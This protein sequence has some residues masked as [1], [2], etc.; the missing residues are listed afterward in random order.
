MAKK[1][2]KTALAFQQLE[3]GLAEL[4]ESGDWQRY[5]KIQSQFYNYSFNNVLLIL[6]QFPGASRVAGYQRWQELG[7]Q[8]KKGSKSIKI[9]APLKRKVEKENDNGELETKTGIFGFRTVNVFDISQTE[10]EDLPEIAS[11]LT[12]DDQ[13]L[14][15][16]LTAFSHNNQVPVFFKGLLGRANGC[17]RYDA[18]SG[19]P[20]EI[21]VDPLLPKQH[22]A[23]TLSHE[24]AHSIL[25]SR[26]QY[27][28]HIPR[29]QAELEAESVAFIVLHHFGIDSSDYSFP[30]VAGWQ[31]GEDALENLRQSGML[32]QK[33]AN[34]IIDWIETN[35]PTQL[36]A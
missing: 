28:D 34:Q 14:I 18:I 8:V 20:I 25:H 17:C 3:V 21:V 7:R 27:N 22:Q 2:N 35:F 11:P 5:L 23:K 6:S 32:I 36:A 4:L 16:R 30:Y 31:Q 29:S 12:G 33:A 13:G 9:L 26:T 24:V 1:T 15:D 10:G 19:Q